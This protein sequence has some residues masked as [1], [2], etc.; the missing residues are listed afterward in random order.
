M[1]LNLSKA[2]IK[3]HFTYN[4][5][6]YVLAIPGIFLLWD[7]LFTTTHYRTPENQKLEWYY[8][9]IVQYETEQRAA[10]IIAD[11]AAAVADDVEET[12]FVIAGTDENYGVMQLYV[13]MAAGEGDIYTLTEAE[14]SKDG[15]MMVPLQPYIDDGTLQ[16]GNLNLKK[17]IVKDADTGEKVLCGIPGKYFPGLIEQGFDTTDMTFC[18]LVTGGNV[19]TSVKALNEMLQRYGDHELMGT[20]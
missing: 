3:T 9:G 10:E 1:T 5:W 14:F 8:Q 4:W 15:T 19:D 7:L 2:N 11:V 17:G 20:P 13:W 18:V 12:S 6:K 16:V